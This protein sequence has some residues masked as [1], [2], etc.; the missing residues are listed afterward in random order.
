M[1]EN[2]LHLPKEKLQEG[3]WVTKRR[4]GYNLK[5]CCSALLGFSHLCISNYITLIHFILF[6]CDC[7]EILSLKFYINYSIFQILFIQFQYKNVI[8]SS[9]SWL[10]FPYN[11]ALNMISRRRLLTNKV[12]FYFWNPSYSFLFIN[13]MK[14]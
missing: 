7:V 14:F 10:F 4:L 13:L 6:L 11:S 8:A 1:C 12:L 5:N 3:E 9:S 2:F